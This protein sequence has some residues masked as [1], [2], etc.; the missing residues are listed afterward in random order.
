MRVRYLEPGYKSAQ[1]IRYYVPRPTCSMLR[2]A[3]NGVNN[4]R[5]CV[6]VRVCVLTM[7]LHI[8]FENR[9]TVRT[10]NEER[11]YI[12]LVGQR[13]RGWQICHSLGFF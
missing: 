7:E 5:H 6:R 1:T 9:P 3:R 4:M 2:R 10:G 8:R 11:S 12:N 13:G